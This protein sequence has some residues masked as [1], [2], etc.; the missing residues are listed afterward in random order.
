MEI[1]LPVQTDFFFRVRFDD[2]DYYQHMN[3]NVYLNYCDH[4]MYEFFRETISPKKKINYLFHLVRNEADYYLPATLD[5]ELKIQ[6]QIHKI[7]NTSITFIQK[8]YRN[9]DLLVQIKKTGVFLNSKNGKKCFVPDE[10]QLITNTS[11]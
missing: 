5:E 3:N 8:I 7:G 6:T 1:I 4:A 10:F 11:I 2:C 9:T